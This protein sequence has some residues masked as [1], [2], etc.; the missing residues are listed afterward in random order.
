MQTVYAPVSSTKVKIIESTSYFGKYK[1]AAS[2][3]SIR[4]KEKKPSYTSVYR[5]TGSVDADISIRYGEYSSRVSNWQ[6]FLNWAGFN[7]GQVDGKFGDGTLAQT[8]AFQ[9]R[10]GLTADGIVGPKTLEKANTFK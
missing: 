3:N 4:I 7:C 2:N 6:E 10:F 5:F 1:S 9:A 8:K